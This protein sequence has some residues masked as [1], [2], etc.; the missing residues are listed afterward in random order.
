MQAAGRTSDMI[1]TGADFT[2]PAANT[3]SVRASGGIWLGT[4]S[5]PS[6][7][8]GHF[9]DTSTGAYLTS[10]GTWTNDSDRAKKHDLRPLSTRS[11]LD[12]VANVPIT[13]WSY[14]GDPSTVRHIGP[15]AQD[16]S[17]AFG[18]GLDNR[19]ITTIDEGG[20]APAA[21]I[22]APTSCPCSAA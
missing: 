1:L 6:I 15:M 20:V 16:F 2:S 11:V 19:H 14:K 3:F 4:T 21:T 18:L 7:T 17:K 8:S 12:K 5:S 13:S 10:T 22:T 9:L